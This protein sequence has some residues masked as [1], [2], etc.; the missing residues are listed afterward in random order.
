[1]NEINTIKS[2]FKILKTEHNIEKQILQEKAKKLQQ[3]EKLQIE[4]ANRALKKQVKVPSQDRD[5]KEL[6]ELLE[7]DNGKSHS[8]FN[9]DE[10]K[11]YL[12]EDFEKTSYKKITK[13]IVVT[14]GDGDCFINAIFD[15]LIYNNKMQDMYIRLTKLHEVINKNKNK[16]Y[17]IE[18]IKDDI[19]KRDLLRFNNNII[20]ES[21]DSYE[22]LKSG[23]IGLQYSCIEDNDDIK[24]EPKEVLPNSDYNTLR[25]DFIK[26]MKYTLFLYSKTI[27]R[28]DNI[29]YLK[30]I[31]VNQSFDND[32]ITEKYIKNIINKRILQLVNAGNFNYT[33]VDS[34]TTKEYI[35]EYIKNI[36]TQ[37]LDYSIFKDVD[38]SVILTEEDYVNIYDY[39]ISYYFYNNNVDSDRYIIY[40]YTKILIRKIKNSPFFVIIRTNSGYNPISYL[41]KLKKYDEDK[42]FYIRILNDKMR[43]DSHYTNHFNLIISKKNSYFNKILKECQQEADINDF[44][45]ADEAMARSLAADEAMARSLA[46]EKIV[47]RNQVYN[48]LTPAQLLEQTENDAA[49]A[50]SLLYN[51]GGKRIQAKTLHKREKVMSGP[52]KPSPKKPSPKKPS[53]KKPCKSKQ[54]SRLT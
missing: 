45:A 11:I 32:S 50:R 39:Y 21:S 1:M 30:T 36:G 16:K 49:I 33:L 5:E 51:S 42:T 13:H 37:E 44:L 24:F 22:I 53:P 29:K 48:E 3:E 46:G 38:P 18:N 6:R 54:K 15:Y 14:I 43:K 4:I 40:I 28:I 19:K 9:D 8:S 27:G 7:E 47:T 34:T 10:Y 41:K 35:K 26:C 52:K 17:N 31:L 2:Q 12:D 25:L 20:K 23:N